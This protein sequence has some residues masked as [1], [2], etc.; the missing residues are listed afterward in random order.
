MFLTTD[1]FALIYAFNF[2]N[3]IL[4]KDFAMQ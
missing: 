2:V 1:T 3:P 4:K